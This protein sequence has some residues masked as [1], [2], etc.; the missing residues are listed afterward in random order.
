M[1]KLKTARQKGSQ[2]ELDCEASLKRIFFDLKR[3]YG[4]GMYRGFDL[5]TKNFLKVFECK[6]HKNFSW[7]ELIKY[8]NKLKERA[9]NKQ[10]F[11]LFK[12]NRQPVLVMYEDYESILVRPFEDVFKIDFI[13]HKFRKNDKII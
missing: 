9:G 3:L 13:K 6:R 11:L 5:E 2:F 4:E 12:S 10:P 8:Y 1:V 7:N